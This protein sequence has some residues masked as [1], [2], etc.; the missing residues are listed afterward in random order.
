MKAS[1]RF[2]HKPTKPNLFEAKVSEI[3]NADKRISSHSVGEIEDK[4]VSVDLAEGFNYE[5]RES[6]IAH[7]LRELKQMIKDIEPNEIK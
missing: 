5:G 7:G 6:F 3:I 4:S 1:F 2:Y